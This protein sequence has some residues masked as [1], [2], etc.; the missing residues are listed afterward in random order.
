MIEGKLE[1]QWNHTCA[2]VATLVNVN[3][4]RGQKAISPDDIHP[5][6][7]TEKQQDLATVKHPTS[8]LQC[9]LPKSEQRRLKKRASE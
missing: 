6:R 4:G 7:V 8:I 3:R 9:M 1:S 5:M 2:I